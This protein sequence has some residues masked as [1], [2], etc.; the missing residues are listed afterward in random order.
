MHIYD[1]SSLNEAYSA[2]EHPSHYTHTPYLTA[3]HT[4]MTENVW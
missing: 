1:Q 2:T 4:H 3:I